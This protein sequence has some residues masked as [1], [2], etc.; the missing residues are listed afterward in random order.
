MYTG[1]SL[2]TFRRCN[3]MGQHSWQCGVIVHT[4]TQTLSCTWI[5]EMASIEIIM[6]APQVPVAD[7]DRFHVL[8]GTPLSHKNTLEIQLTKLAT[9]LE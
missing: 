2:K 8:H 1:N 6:K 7:P 4:T 3:C 5:I 9:Q